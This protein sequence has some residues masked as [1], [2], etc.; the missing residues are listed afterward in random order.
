MLFSPLS[1]C[2]FGTV[3]LDEPAV[4]FQPD[5]DSGRES[6]PA[7]TNL[8]HPNQP[9]P[10]FGIIRGPTA[11]LQFDQVFVANMTGN[12]V[13]F[14]SD[15]VAVEFPKAVNHL[16]PVVTFLLGV[17]AARLAVIQL[18]H[19]SW[20]KVGVCLILISGLW[21]IVALAIPNLGS[22]LIPVLA[23]TMGAQNATLPRIEKVPVNT[24]FITGNLEKLGEAI[25]G[26]LR[27]P[28]DRDDRLK[29]WAVG[30]SGLLT[31]WEQPPARWLR[32]ISDA[33]RFCYLPECSVSVLF[34]SLRHSFWKSE[35]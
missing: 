14:A 5:F 4:I 18:D 22:I 32:C 7:T 8:T 11:F 6:G 2:S 10:F 30:S 9:P 20:P 24:A 13:L 25:A 19:P 23:F 35:V 1:Q 26:V 21:T 16:L 31:L 29:I 28:A 12:T 3:E 33:T 27:K 15:L 17:L 34:S